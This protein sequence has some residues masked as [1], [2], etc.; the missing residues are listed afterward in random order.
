LRNKISSLK[1]SATDDFVSP[2]A[3][4][5]VSYNTREHLR[6]CLESV[7]PER[8]AETV[9]VDNGSTDGSVE[10]VREEYPEVELI[11]AENHGYGAGAN[12]AFAAT[13]A[14]YVLLLNTDTVLRP[15]A[16]QALADHLAAH[17]R[18]GIVGPR[19]LN[20]D[21]SLQR[22]CAPF[23]YPLSKL[24]RWLP[25]G[26]RTYL[27]TWSHDAPRVVPYVLGA[28]LALRRE[29]IDAIGG[30]DERFFMYFEETDLA[31]RLSRHG[32]E[33]HF[34]PAAEVAHEGSASTRQLSAPMLLELYRS[35]TRFY[36][37]H[38]GPLIRT[39]AI[40]LKRIELLIRLAVTAGRLPF[41]AERSEAAD[42]MSAMRI[43]LASRWSTRP[44]SPREL[45]RTPRGPERDGAG[46]VAAAR[47]PGPE[48]R[49]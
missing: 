3:V 34:T 13:T 44:R 22:S 19:L 32:W 37:L 5:I 23:P 47:A 14:P 18:A 28:A 7:A 36:E 41:A 1:L 6:A 10:M 35:M 27:P 24:A 39:A 2:I 12:R 46:P 15:G 25:V 30:F 11:E 49:R 48:V 26:R 42:E 31:L 8:P 38:H 43:V 20:P 16:L 33:T 40:S 4:A 45:A 17:H 21:G 9:V 29:A